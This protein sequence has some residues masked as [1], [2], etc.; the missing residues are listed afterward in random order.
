MSPSLSSV[1]SNKRVMVASAAAI[2]GGAAFDGVIEGLLPGDPSYSLTPVL[3]A[4]VLVPSLLVVGARLPRRWLALL[5]PLG[6]GLIA[7]A[8]ATTPG[9]GD[10]AVLYVWPVLW[11]TFF[12]GRRGATAI[13]ACV[14]VGHAAVLLELPA[15]SSYPGRWVDVMVCV[16]LVAGVVLTLVNRNELLLAQLQSEARTDTLTGLLNRRGF[17]ERARLE[18]A[19][20]RRDGRSIAVVAFDI[21]YFK[22]IND[23]W[24]HE[25]GDR[26]LARIGLLLASHSRDIDVAARIGGEEFAVLLPGSNS[27]DADGFTQRVHTALAAGYDPEGLPVVRVSAGIIAHERPASVE[28]LLRGADT[29]LYEAKR[30]GRNQTVRL[31]VANAQS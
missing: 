24:G 27:D 5:G 20:A 25:T 4:L 11:M 9:A 1:R 17:D 31:T 19:H 7:Y 18:L 26:V 16:C 2:Y 12:F 3:V 14:G 22:R 21:D 10:G 6:V 29:A 30:G 23:E 15:A 13:V 28:E 8:L